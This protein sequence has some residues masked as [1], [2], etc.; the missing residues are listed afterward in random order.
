MKKIITVKGIE[1]EIFRDESGAFVAIESD[2]CDEAFLIF[3]RKNLPDNINSIP[4]MIDFIEHLH[5]E[6]YKK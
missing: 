3:I 6:F 1:F 2:Y 4:K 5:A